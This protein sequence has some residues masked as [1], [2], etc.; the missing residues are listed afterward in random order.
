MV[1][2]R[3]KVRM[4]ST[5]K[6][7]MLPVFDYMMKQVTD[8]GIEIGSLQGNTPKQ[9]AVVNDLTIMHV[10]SIST[11]SELYV[12]M[13]REFANLIDNRMGYPEISHTDNDSVLYALKDDKLVG[14][15]VYNNG[16]TGRSQMVYKVLS[17]T[18][19]NH[20]GQGIYSTLHKYLEA[21]AFSQGKTVISSLVHK[22]NS[23][24]IKAGEKIGLVA[25]FNYMLKVLD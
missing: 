14:M 2:K 8:V 16:P 23:S 19:E 11:V 1:H 5:V 15:I 25:A 4:E 20:R 21:V 3:N 24:L 18:E 7:G 22:R 9:I 6:V 13:L 10:N 17:V 12:F